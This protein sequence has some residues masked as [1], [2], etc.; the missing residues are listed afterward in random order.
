[1]SK[2]S[3][4][5]SFRS[6]AAAVGWPRTTLTERLAH[7][8]CPVKRRPPWPRSVVR[9]LKRWAASKSRDNAE[10]PNVESPS[11]ARIR[12][13]R[14]RGLE[15]DLAERERTLVPREEMHAFLV[16]LSEIL[17]GIGTQLQRQFGTEALRVLE[18]GLD[19]F[20]GEVATYF[21]A[22]TP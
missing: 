3:R 7:P 6:L 1:M 15:L 22:T 8:G 10:T 18:E 5:S 19:Q 9:T 11:M 16:R 4:I 21:G 12:D 14:A 17:R 13:L 20:D 2:A